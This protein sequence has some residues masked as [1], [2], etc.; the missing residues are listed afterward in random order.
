MHPL[1]FPVIS[2]TEI[3]LQPNVEADEKI[4]TAHLFEDKFGNAGSAVSPG[5]RDNRPD[6]S[7]DDGL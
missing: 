2:A 5:Y 1:C 7:A 3:L 6:I 4:T